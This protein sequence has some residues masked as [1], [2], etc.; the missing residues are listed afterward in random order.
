MANKTNPIKLF[1]KEMNKYV[2]YFHLKYTKFTNPHGL[3]DKGNK[4][5]ASDIAIL[6]FNA[7]KDNRFAE[8]VSKQKY[9]CTTYLK[10]GQVLTSFQRDQL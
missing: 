5:T 8:I 7:M 1:V 4:S 2:R 3:A 10:R 6:A 9:E